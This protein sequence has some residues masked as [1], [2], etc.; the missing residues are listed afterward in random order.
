MKQQRWHRDHL[1]A[2]V[3]VTDTAD[4]RRIGHLLDLSPAGLGVAGSGDLPGGDDT[5]LRLDFPMAV[6][7]RYELVLPVRQRWARYT[8][9]QHWHAGYRILDMPDADIPVIEHLA[10]WYA[11]P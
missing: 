4:G 5:C 8:E 3:V 6:K 2:N 7:G 11:E 9:G 1:K 10:T